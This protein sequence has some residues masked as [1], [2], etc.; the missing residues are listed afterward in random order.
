MHESKYEIVEG[1]NY[2]VCDSIPTDDDYN[3][4]DRKNSTAKSIKKLD[5]N[6]ELQKL[7]NVPVT[8]EQKDS[9]FHQDLE[10]LIKFYKNARIYR[11]INGNRI[12]HKGEIIPTPYQKMIKINEEIKNF[13]DIKT[14][15]T[16]SPLIVKN[17]K[18]TTNSCIFNKKKNNDSRK[19]LKNLKKYSLKK[20]KIYDGNYKI[21]TLKNEIDPKKNYNNF[22][23]MC[24]DRFN[25]RVYSI[26]NLNKEN[27]HHCLSETSTKNRKGINLTETKIENSLSNLQK[28]KNF[29]NLNSKIHLKKYF[30]DSDFNQINKWELKLISP[31]II[32]Q[33]SQRRNTINNF[34]EKNKTSI[35]KFSKCNNYNTP[36]K[37]VSFTGKLKNYDLIQFNMNQLLKKDMKHNEKYVLNMRKN[38]CDKKV[39]LS[40]IIV[41]KGNKYRNRNIL[42]N[43]KK[44]FTLSYGNTCESKLEESTN[45][46]PNKHNLY[47]KK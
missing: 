2:Y 15:K 35:S 22:S 24:P 12:T 3:G 38:L 17:D 10:N 31:N 30:Y 33:Y 34:S 44:G 42:S 26:N 19:I 25:T 11:D 14:N 9:K 28:T 4:K 40:G 39:R 41:N 27:H 36:N 18:T 23:Q 20:L 8:K 43:F 5:F 46:K 16:I 47:K 37:L 6:L 21:K 32:D 45:S 1:L 29:S 13:Y 7:I